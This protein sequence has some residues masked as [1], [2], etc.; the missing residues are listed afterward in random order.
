[1]N[2]KNNSG[3]G[4][5]RPLTKARAGGLRRKPSPSAQCGSLSPSSSWCCDLCGSSFFP[6]LFH[7]NTKHLGE[8]HM[9]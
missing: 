5:K 7:T 1:M 6:L 3:V 9:Q 8:P 2:T 4:F